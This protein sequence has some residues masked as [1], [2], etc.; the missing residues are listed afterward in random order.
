[1]YSKLTILFLFL[2]LGALGQEHSKPKFYASLGAGVGNYWGFTPAVNYGIKDRFTVGIQ[3]LGLYQ[4]ADKPT[5]YSTGLVDLFELRFNQSNKKLHAVAFTGGQYLTSSLRNC[6]WLIQGGVAF[7]SHSI[8]TNWEQTSTTYFPWVEN[9]SYS[10]H[11]DYQIGLLL[12]PQFEFASV[13]NMGISFG[14]YALVSKSTRAY[15]FSL[16]FLVGRIR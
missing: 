13:D 3:Y 7:L 5:D 12:S 8:P 4:K 10:R 15:G 1:M 14:P 9:Y 11:T 16:S 2:T 6:R